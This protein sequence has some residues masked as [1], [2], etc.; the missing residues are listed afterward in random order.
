M[1]M[2]YGKQ[3]NPYDDEEDQTLNRVHD[4]LCTEAKRLGWSVYSSDCGY[5]LELALECKRQ[6]VHM[7]DIA[8][9]AIYAA[10]HEGG[11]V[12]REV[13]VPF[14]GNAVRTVVLIEARPIPSPQSRVRN[15]YQMWDCTVCGGRYDDG[16]NDGLCP[17]CRVQV[18]C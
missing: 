18:C 5:C 4:A 9:R 12:E 7:K 10:I 3:P 13:K 15:N 6:K 14:F 16:H 17:V 2:H 11:K 8:R 1:R